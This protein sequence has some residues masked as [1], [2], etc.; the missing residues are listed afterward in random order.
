V[1]LLKLFYQSIR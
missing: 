1:Y